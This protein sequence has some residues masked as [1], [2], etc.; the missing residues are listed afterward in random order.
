ML[1]WYNPGSKRT[2]FVIP[3]YG[4]YIFEAEKEK[5]KDLYEINVLHIVSPNPLVEVRGQNILRPFPLILKLLDKLDGVL[6]RDEIILTVLA[7][8]NDREKNYVEKAEERVRAL[9]GNILNLEKAYEN[10]MKKQKIKSKDTLRNYTRFILAT[11]KY[12]DYAKPK[13]V[14]GIYGN[15]KVNVYIQTEYAKQKVKEIYKSKDI[16]SS[17][18]EYFNIRERAAFA[19][20]MFYHQFRQIGGYKVDQP[21]VKKEINKVSKISKRIINK[22][23]IT[24]NSKILHFPFQETSKEIFK[25]NLS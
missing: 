20:Y 18:L 14:K 2:N 23:K 21:D 15:K 1:G 25:Y 5:L 16:R 24:E 17:D 8:S 6:H 9:R 12:L 22:F 4:E 19:N 7:C 10:L 11:L 3:P 13:R